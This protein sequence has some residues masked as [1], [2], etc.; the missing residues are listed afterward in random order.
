MS[1]STGSKLNHIVARKG[2][3]GEQVLIGYRRVLDGLNTA[4]EIAADLGMSVTNFYA[5][6]SMLR[7]RFA[8]SGVSI[9]KK[10]RES[11]LDV[12]TVAALFSETGET[13]ETAAG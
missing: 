12:Q 3:R 9:P 5:R 11:T 7:K 2:T 8:E 4:A 1:K 10:G 6:V 13:G